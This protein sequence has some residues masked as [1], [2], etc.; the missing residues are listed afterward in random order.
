MAKYSLNKINPSTRAVTYELNR[1]FDTER[2]LFDFLARASEN[3]KTWFYGYGSHI[4]RD[5]VVIAHTRDYDEMMDPDF[6]VDGENI[7]PSI[8][9]LI[10]I[11]NSNSN[12]G[13]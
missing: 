6:R 10:E 8:T 9:K 1:S 3:E 2:E 13:E 12:S 5:D 7:A 4:M 11:A